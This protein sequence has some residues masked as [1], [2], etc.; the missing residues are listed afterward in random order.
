VTLVIL[1]RVN[2]QRVLAQMSSLDLIITVTIGSAFGRVI[3]AR[4]VAVVEVVAAFVALVVLERIVAELWLRTPRLR[5]ITTV[6]PA[7][8]YYDGR[9]VHRAMRRNRLREEDLHLVA[10]QDG[11]GSLDEVRAIVLEANGSFS[12]LSSD[13]YGDGETVSR[14]EER[15]G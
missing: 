6:S 12:I 8:L 11:K 2:G 5:R 15:G 10:R 1:L 13:N 9:V 14:L 4:D 7:L 3:T